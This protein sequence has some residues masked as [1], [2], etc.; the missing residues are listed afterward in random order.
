MRSRYCLARPCL[1]SVLFSLPFWLECT[2]YWQAGSHKLIT[3]FVEL[4]GQRDEAPDP[5][6]G[7][8]VTKMLEN[9]AFLVHPFTFQVWAASGTDWAKPLGDIDE[10][11]PKAARELQM[12]VCVRDENIANSGV[13]VYVS[14]V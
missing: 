11:F 8:T 4:P 10:L 2:D 1:Y 12:A 14:P 5:A 3:L 13:H 7:E 6:P 9:V